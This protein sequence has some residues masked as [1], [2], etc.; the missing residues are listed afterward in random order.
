MSKLFSAV[1]MAGFLS[2]SPASASNEQY[3]HQIN[4]KAGASGT[5][6]FVG[7]WQTTTIKAGSDNSFRAKARSVGKR[8]SKIAALR[9][10]AMQ[11]SMQHLPR[12][13]PYASNYPRMVRVVRAY[14]RKHAAN[15]NAARLTNMILQ[16]VQQKYRYFIRPKLRTGIN[17]GIRVLKQKLHKS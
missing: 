3:G 9:A 1:V 5:P 2:L 17:K 13:R 16:H 10:E 15:P 11:I 4:N 6:V 7:S 8:T 12:L 14:W